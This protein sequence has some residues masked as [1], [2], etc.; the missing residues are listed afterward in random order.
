GGAVAARRQ[1]A[2]DPAQAVRLG[3]HED[4]PAAHE[5]L[6][7][8]GLADARPGELIEDCQHGP[9]AHAGG[10]RPAAEPGYAGGAPAEADDREA[11]GQG[12]TDA[13]GLGGGDELGLLVRVEN[14]GAF[15]APLQVVATGLELV[16]LLAEAQG[17][18]AVRK[19]VEVVAG[20]AGVAVDG[21]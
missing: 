19:A 16:E 8:H 14:D 12:E 6:V 10:L 21:L 7:G 3:H 13:L 11:A 18:L 5:D 15:Q 2:A 1:P 20:G 4:G 9:G 17:F